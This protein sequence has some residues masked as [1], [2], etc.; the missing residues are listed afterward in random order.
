M[1][2]VTDFNHYVTD[3]RAFIESLF[4]FKAGGKI[5]IIGH[6]MGGLISLKLSAIL[7]PTSVHS[8]STVAPMLCFKTPPFPWSVAG[9]LGLILPNIGLG[10]HYTVG[11]PKPNWEPVLQNWPIKCSH[12]IERNACWV[13]QQFANPQITLAGPSNTWV[14]SAWK[15]CDTFLKRYVHGTERYPVPWLIVRATE[16]RFVHEESQ[17]MFAAAQRGGG[18]FVRVEG[19]YHEVL[20]ECDGLRDR[21]L[22]EITEFVKVRK[23][24]A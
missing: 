24:E 21:A 2:H 8:V 13:R 11:F 20:I 17:D 1:S 6:S 22:G 18:G 10:S 19:A 12:S 5:S 3:A 23:R 16:D 4:D 7:G 9:V 14:A 15:G